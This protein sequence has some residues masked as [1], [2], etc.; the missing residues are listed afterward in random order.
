MPVVRAPLFSVGASG[1]LG[2]EIYF[3]GCGPRA[4]VKAQSRPS[5]SPTAPQLQQRSRYQDG[6]DAFNAADWTA[7]DLQAWSTN[8]S[9]CTGPSSALAGF[10]KTYLTARSD[11]E[12]YNVADGLDLSKTTPTQLDVRIW[13]A[14][15]ST[16]TFQLASRLVPN[17]A[18]TFTDTTFTNATQLIFVRSAPFA[19]Q[20]FDCYIRE[21]GTP[22]LGR[23]SG[24]F[25]TRTPRP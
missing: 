19:G 18:W 1:R 16:S 10:L 14:G 5:G 12:T 3:T 2:S 15:H 6:V 21:R 20:L 24:F 4:V 13:I 23:R 25:S 22:Q 8:G 9:I 7:L 11:G 17:G